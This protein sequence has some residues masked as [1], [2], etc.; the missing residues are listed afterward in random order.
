MQAG[1][2]AR[3]QSARRRPQTRADSTVRTADA[4]CRPSCACGASAHNLCTGPP[5]A[6]R[7]QNSMPSLCGQEPGTRWR[8]RR[9]RSCNVSDHRAPEPHLGTDARNRRRRGGLVGDGENRAR[10]AA[11]LLRPI[12]HRDLSRHETIYRY[13]FVRRA[14]EHHMLRTCRAPEPGSSR[15]PVHGPPVK[16]ASR[17]PPPPA[18]WS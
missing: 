9:R 7:A 6:W 3:C 4:T 13:C 8:F 15:R 18:Q 11:R 17:P 12:P 14:G 10:R 16:R 2:A 1:R 5:H